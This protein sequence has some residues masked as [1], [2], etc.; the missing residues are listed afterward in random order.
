MSDD[1]GVQAARALLGAAAAALADADVRDEALGVYESAKT[2]LG[3]RR[4]A[5]IRQTGRVW[6]LGALLLDRSGSVWAT[7]AITRVTDPGR[8]QFVARSMELRR[9]Y[10]AAAVRGRIPF[11]DTVNHGAVAIPL[12]DSLI[13]ATGPL[14]VRDGAPYVRWSPT[15]DVAVPL[16]DYLRDR[17][18][19]LLHPPQGS[20]D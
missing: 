9:A 20:T 11:G 2:R 18:E 6:R 13:G 10:R 14:F 17:V 15:S 1:P 5:I 3:V 12:D 8:S 16:A 7:A 19:L 4:D